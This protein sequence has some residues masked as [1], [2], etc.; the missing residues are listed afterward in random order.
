MELLGEAPVSF[1][2]D[3][4][5]MRLRQKVLRKLVHE[6]AGTRTCRHVLTTDVDIYI[7]MGI[8]I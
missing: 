8:D 7:C 3:L 6:Q 5:T 4:Q 1:C 2:S